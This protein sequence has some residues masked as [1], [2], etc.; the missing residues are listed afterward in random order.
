MKF[1]G[2]I[3][4]TGLIAD[5]LISLETSGYISPKPSIGLPAPSKTLPRIS[6]ESL[7]SMGLPV[8]TVAVFLSE[9]PFVPSKT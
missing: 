7:S 9:S 2:Y 4:E 5:P 3:L 8:G 1:L 6:S